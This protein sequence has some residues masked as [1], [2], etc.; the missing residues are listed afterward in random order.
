MDRRQQPKAALEL[1]VGGA[2][3]ELGLQRAVA[4]QDEDGAIDPRDGLDELLDAPVAREPALVEDDPRLGR[5]PQGLVKAAP[6]RR[7]GSYRYE[8]FRTMSGSSTCQREAM[9][10]AYGRFT[11]TTRAG[12]SSPAAFS[13]PD[14]RPSRPRQP[15]EVAGVDVDVAGVVDRARAVP[16]GEVQ[17]NRDP[18]VGHAVIEVGGRQRVPARLGLRPDDERDRG[19]PPGRFRDG[20]QAPGEAAASTA[21]LCFGIGRRKRRNRCDGRPAAAPTRSRRRARQALIQR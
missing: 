4:E 18:H 7:G 5:Q 6:P 3:L 13:T 17:G 14:D 2:S 20:E 16:P 15:G 21:Q 8:Q 19:D 9:T 1:G 11:V 10:S 12:P